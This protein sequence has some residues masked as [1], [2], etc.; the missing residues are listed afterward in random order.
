MKLR[1]N[2]DQFYTN[3]L[4]AKKLT[5]IFIS[6]VRKLGYEKFGIIEPSAGSGS[7]I[8]VIKAINKQIPIFAFDIDPKDENI[9]PK[10]FLTLNFNVLPLSFKKNGLVLGNPPFGKKGKLAIKFIDKSLEA[11]DTIGFILPLTFRRY[12]VQSKLSQDLRLILDID[13][14]P[15]SFTLLDGKEYK[16]KTCF[17][18]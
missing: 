15:N 2:F 12:S 7:F 11:V 3:P 1:N 8:K 6:Q 5:N 13:L 14:A 18:I 17:Q 4:I 10:D 16:L 9:I